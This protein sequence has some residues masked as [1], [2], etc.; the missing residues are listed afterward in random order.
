[1]VVGSHLRSEGTAAPVFSQVHQEQIVAV[2]TT[3]NIVALVQYAAPTMLHLPTTNG[4]HRNGD[5]IKMGEAI[6][7]ITIDLEWV[8]VHP[9]GL[10]K[11]GRPLYQNQVPCSRSAPRSWRSAG[12]KRTSCKV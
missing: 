4:E 11:P 8:Q 7:A 6:G 10:V 9:T 1:M 2:E 3:K 12:L 5:A